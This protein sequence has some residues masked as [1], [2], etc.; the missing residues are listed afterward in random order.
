MGW[1]NEGGMINPVKSTEFKTSAFARD[2]TLPIN[3]LK[4]RV[5]M[6]Q[7]LNFT[8]LDHEKQREHSLN[9]FG[10]YQS[11]NYADSMNTLQEVVE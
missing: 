7:T 1:D 10:Y 4:K 8:G 3:N 6:K 11:H 5:T 9:T 2:I